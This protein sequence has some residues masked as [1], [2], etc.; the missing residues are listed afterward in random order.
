MH[1]V[2]FDEGASLI[3]LAPFEWANHN[4]LTVGSRLVIHGRMSP[5]C[6]LVL[7]HLQSLGFVPVAVVKDPCTQLIPSLCFVSSATPV[8]ST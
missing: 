1:G 2:S 8:A 7:T 5:R 6:R 4:Q 3:G